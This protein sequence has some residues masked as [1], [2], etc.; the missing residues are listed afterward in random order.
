MHPLWT[1]H[2]EKT[3]LRHNL[4]PGV[5]GVTGDNGLIDTLSHLHNHP[6]IQQIFIN[7]QLFWML[8]WAKGCVP[9]LG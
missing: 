2:V 6:P 7:L 3:N 9:T 8:C 5:N 4:H 1:E